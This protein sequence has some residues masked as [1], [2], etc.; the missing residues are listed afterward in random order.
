MDLLSRLDRDGDGLDDR[1]EVAM[2][3]D[4]TSARGR[5][6]RRRRSRTATAC[7]NAAGARRRHRT[8]AAS[9]RLLLAEGAENA[10]FKHAPRAGQS[11]RDRRDRRRFA[12]TATTAPRR[13]IK[14]PRRRPARAAPCSSTRSTAAAGVVRDLDRGERRPIVADRTMSWDRDR[15]RRARRA[16]QRIGVR[17]RLVP[18]RRRHRSASRSSICCRTP[19]T[20]PA[21][22]T[23][24]YLRPAPLAADRADLSRC[25]RTRA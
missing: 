7:T 25:R 11:R 10:F 13:P 12:S 14:R 17:R 8:R 15:V 6:R 16:R 20:P 5:R 4:Y 23:I 9:Q 1:W 21:T 18:R 24:R 2:G 19:A 3:L 22:V